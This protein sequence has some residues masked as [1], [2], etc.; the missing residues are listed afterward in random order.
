MKEFSRPKTR[1]NFS[2]FPNHRNP[3]RVFFPNRRP[4]RFWPIGLFFLL[5]GLVPWTAVSGEE[6]APELPFSPGERLVFELRWEFVPAGRATLAVLPPTEID[7]KPVR[8]FVMTAR[9]NGF[10][11]TFYKVRDR[12]ESFVDLGMNHSVLYKKR[13]REG[14][15]RRDIEVR[16]DWAAGAA[17]YANFG[18]PRDPLPL[19]AGT[20]DPLSAFYF[21]RTLS[22]GPDMVVERPI[23]DGK[24]NVVGQLTVVTRE[25]ITVKGT[26]YDTYRL[27]P[28]LK[29]VG[30]VFEKTEDAEMDVWVTADDRH[31]PVRIQSSV[32]VGDFIA[33]L[34]SVEEANEP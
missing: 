7:G 6:A 11:D 4:F 32:V 18:K 30:G 3:L 10:M 22:L 14:K 27:V 28:D 15:T 1:E 8:H 33:E 21:V 24:K 2:I 34:I 26:R 12:I 16:F 5:W 25:T 20:F 19:K 17:H 31:I 13:Q 29:H 23:T 9:T